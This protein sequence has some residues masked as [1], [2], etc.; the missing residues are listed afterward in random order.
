MRRMWTL[1]SIRAALPPVL[2]LLL[3][4]GCGGAP[5]PVEEA[6]PPAAA[7]AP[8]A[9]VPAPTPALA[10]AEAG[11]APEIP[12]AGGAP[13]EALEPEVGPPLP[14]DLLAPLPEPPTP[15]ELL[16]EAERLHEAGETGA[17]LDAAVRARTASPDLPGAAMT[18]A[19]MRFSANDADGGLPLLESLIEKGEGGLEVVHTYVLWAERAGRLD[20]C[21]EFLDARTAEGMEAAPEVT[22]ALGW[23]QHRRGAQDKAVEAW[24]RIETFP[25]AAPYLVTLARLRFAA[26]DGSGA[27]RALLRALA[28]P[29]LK[30]EALLAQADFQ[31]AEGR[32]GAAEREYGRVLRDRPDDYGTLMDMGLLKLGQGDAAAAAG[33][34]EKAAAVSAASPEAWNDLGLARRARGDF[35]GAREAYEKALAVRPG[36]AP[37]LKN[38]GILVEKYLGRP[39]EAMPI[40]AA[41][42]EARPGDEE[43]QRW[44]KAAE[45]LSKEEAQ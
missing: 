10:P 18:E 37:A 3:L 44:L 42:L 11:A 29:V 5:A 45:R 27:D 2:L 1:D 12:A 40:Y 33:Y 39:A 7:E 31:R 26:G 14:P 23:V 8:E 13:A 34:F 25:Q 32:A 20:R 28:D 38:L 4:A 9:R 41:Y 30:P 35:A 16:A 21:A 43:V 6:K 22:G 17:A 15:E 19:R 36:Y 24:T